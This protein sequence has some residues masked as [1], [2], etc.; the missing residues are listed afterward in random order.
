MTTFTLRCDRSAASR[1]C[2]T[3]PPAGRALSRIPDRVPVGS[4]VASDVVEGPI[5][6]AGHRRDSGSFERRLLPSGAPCAAGPVR[7]GPYDLYPGTARRSGHGGPE[8]ADRGRD[9]DAD[10][11]ESVPDRYRDRRTAVNDPRGNI[12]TVSGASPSVTDTATAVMAA[13]GTW[14][15]GTS[16]LRGHAGPREGGCSPHR[17][18]GRV[19][20]AA[21]GCVSK[22]PGEGDG[23][24][25][26]DPE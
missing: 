10:G 24:C 1:T 3:G 12:V 2:Q 18:L 6:T 17:L 4:W 9:E 22:V 14:A 21:Q 16:R 23:E 26:C 25:F 20:E 8:D 13:C 11:S 5:K 15:V 7:P 19:A